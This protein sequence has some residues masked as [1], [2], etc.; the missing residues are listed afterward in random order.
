[1]P[2][3]ISSKV[4]A[5]VALKKVSFSLSEICHLVVHPE[6]RGIGLGKLLVEKAVKNSKASFLYATIRSDNIASQK[7]FIANQFEKVSEKVV[8]DHTLFMYVRK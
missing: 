4:F 1:M 5:S 6:M 2:T 3:V 8:D 7:A